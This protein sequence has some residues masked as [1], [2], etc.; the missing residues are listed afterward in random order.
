M[1]APVFDMFAPEMCVDPYPHYAAIRRSDPI[2]ESALG[3]F[4]LFRYADVARFFTDKSLEHQY[5]M[6]QQMRGGPGVVEQPYYEVFRRMVFVLDN[7]DHRRVRLLFAKSFTPAQ[8]R[9][10]HGRVVAIADGLLDAVIDDGGMDFVADFAV[11][12]PIRVV[13]ALLGVPRQ[14]QDRIGRISH[15]LNPVLQFLPMDDATMNDANAAVIE[16][17][18]YFRD[19]ADHKRRNPADDLLTQMVAA[20]DENEM[21]DDDELVANAILLYLAGHETS[22]GAGGLALLALHRHPDQLAILAQDR[23][24]IPNAVTELFRYDASGQATARVTTT[25]VTFGENEIP[26]GR[27]IVAWIGAANRDP[28][29]YP[30]PDVLDVRRQIDHIVTFGGGAHY[31]LGQALARQELAVTLEVLFDRLPDLRLTDM[32]PPHRETSLMRGLT[33]LP[34]AWS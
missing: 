3:Y 15:L 14:D 5:A 24:L 7:P 11:P 8:I 28:D 10:L 31:C 18:G 26:A 4:M 25:P 21:L 16:L 20:V 17:T 27:G 22:A 32:D 1:A 30:E 34:V 19:L 33:A 23:S 29:K 9:Q 12:L 13:G 2:H 6:T